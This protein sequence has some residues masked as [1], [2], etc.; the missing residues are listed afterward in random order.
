M[1]DTDTSVLTPAFDRDEF[2]RNDDDGGYV[3]EIAAHFRALPLTSEQLAQVTHLVV[4]PN[5]EIWF[6]ID[7]E[8][9]GGD[10]RFTP[11]TYADVLL[12]PNLV[13]LTVDNMSD[14]D[15]DL[16]A[17]AVLRQR[18]VNVQVYLGSTPGGQHRSS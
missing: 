16:S 11:R 15:T 10:G 9:T 12:L 7:E 1:Y 13:Y 17:L 8:W 5:L 18:D 6:Q 4:D 2:L 14:G 3:E